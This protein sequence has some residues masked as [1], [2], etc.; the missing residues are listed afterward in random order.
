MPAGNSD[1]GLTPGGVEAVAD[2]PI[3]HRFDLTGGLGHRSVRTT[4]R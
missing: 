2:V 1:G 3:D 4:S